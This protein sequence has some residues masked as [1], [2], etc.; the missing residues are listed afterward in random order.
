MLKPLLIVWLA[1]EAGAAP[2]AAPSG[3]SKALDLYLRGDFA[4]SLAACDGALREKSSYLPLYGLRARVWNTLGNYEA[5]DSDVQ[6]VLSG[7]EGSAKGMEEYLAH[8]SVQVLVGDADTALA[9]FDS[10]RHWEGAVTEALAGRARAWRV[11]GEPAKALAEFTD[12]FKYSAEPAP[13]YRYNR[14]QAYF[15]LERYDDAVKELT[16]ALKSNR[17]FYLAYSLL[18]AALAKKGDFPRA[19]QAYT[20]ALGLNREHVFA[21]L[22][23]AATRL[24]RGM[25]IEAFQDFT[26]AA[27]VR[28]Y[29][30]TVYLNRA[31][32]YYRRGNRD[33]ALAD[34]R[35]AL[36]LD[37]RD[38]DAA[39]LI[40]DRFSYFLLWGEAY[41]AVSRAYELRPSGKLLIRKAQILESM[42]RRNE[43]IEYL[44]AA[45]AKEPGLAEAWI[46]RGQLHSRKNEDAD[47]LSDFNQA[48]KVAPKN[49]DALL[50]RGS[51]FAR[52]GKPNAAMDDFNA[53][54]N[55]APTNA[56]AFNNRG[57]LQAN[58]FFE[59]DKAEK[60]I[61]QAVALKPKDPGYRF[62][63]GV[64][65]LKRRDYA[66]ALEAFNEAM[67][68]KGPPARILQYRA[69]VRSLLG[70]QARAMQD[71]QSAIEKEPNSAA[72][73]DVLG[74]IRM[75]GRDFEVAMQDFEQA[76][77]I[78]SD[79]AAARLHY[80]LALANLGKLKRARSQIDEATDT[81]KSNKEAWTELCHVRRLM[82]DA[83]DAVKDC[84][85]AME[86]DPVYAP[87][88]FHRGLS[89]L[90]VKQN[91]KAVEDLDRAV[92]LG[93]KRPES[94]LALSIAHAAARQFRQAHNA[95]LES[96]RVDPN[97]HT[98]E[99][100]FG[101]ERGD[102]EDYYNALSELESMTDT[103][104]S[105]PYI[106]LVRGDAHHNAGRYDRAVQE[107]T[108]AMEINGLLAEAYAARAVALI[109]QDAL[110][111]AQQDL[112]RAIELDSKDPGA[113]V[114]LVVLHGIQGRY[115]EALKRAE[116]AVALDP[117]W[118]EGRLRMANIFYFLRDYKKAVDQYRK[119]VELDSANP[120]AHNGLGLGYFALKDYDK[121]VGSFS[122]AITLYPK[123]DR[124]YKNRGSAYAA[125]GEY[126]N[127][128][129]DFKNAGLVNSDP[130][131]VEN[132]SVLV[133]EAETQA[134]AAE[135]NSVQ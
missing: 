114:R 104:N 126:A 102:K 128:A 110:D 101:L 34:Y 44:N 83:S 86:I 89:F 103:D 84:S 62:N 59:L 18:G 67:R 41:R 87:A 14:A 70:D 113:Y 36:G 79:Y 42:K 81:D 35:K 129:A 72:L 8:G 124:Y 15:E 64:V 97:A 90:A 21:Y 134:A 135:A 123:S 120:A 93:F 61:N 33:E 112:L 1:A 121:S 108:K 13:L 10:A 49:V 7:F 37:L 48:I 82:K 39:A 20:R 66:K 11:R 31:E 133:R 22:G 80:G 111:A 122:A 116:K 25:E 68:L 56:E 96:L 50:A 40:A 47:A 2:A 75:R 28:P 19:E 119:A 130:E 69:E 26:E 85:R 91:F 127:A 107:Y 98:P 55:I 6:K 16:Q 54:A 45:V 9:S 106:Y 99:L 76:M 30:A 115:A 88:Y 27:S 38:P 78:D 77:K 65:E 95:Y 73:H 57:A 29:D 100:L 4:E 132:Y 71:V 52:T 74:M 24:A 105:D 117:D 94:Y 5:M 46:A 51:F 125:K 17:N 60:D 118:V 43:A 109:D 58:A 32:A 131:Q 23:R 92:R 53:A 12:V 63:L 3:Y